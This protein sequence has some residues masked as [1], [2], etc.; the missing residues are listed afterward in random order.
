M[1]KKTSF[2]D[3]QS[4]FLA[5]WNFPL[6]FSGIPDSLYKTKRCFETF[7]SRWKISTFVLRDLRDF[8]IYNAREQGAQPRTTVSISIRYH[9]DFIKSTFLIK[10][11]RNE[12]NRFSR[13]DSAGL[14]RASLAAPVDGTSGT[15]GGTCLEY[16][17]TF[18][19]VCRVRGGKE[20]DYGPR[21]YSGS[22]LDGGAGSTAESQIL[23]RFQGIVS[24]RAYYTRWC[25]ARTR[26]R[27]SIVKCAVTPRAISSPC[28]RCYRNSLMI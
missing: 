2:F 20:R 1:K 19:Y 14:Q 28:E 6:I 9:P 12:K 10:V 3:F 17:C 27:L 21:L 16:P 23:G 22:G 25:E 26:D 13:S 8:I 15:T 18:A 5:K 11:K 7:S 24:P 4:I